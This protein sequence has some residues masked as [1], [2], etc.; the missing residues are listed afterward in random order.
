MDAYYKSDDKNKLWW[1]IQIY[2]KRKYYL[3]LTEVRI[4][5]NRVV[6]S[7]IKLLNQCKTTRRIMYWSYDTC[8]VK[9]LRL[10][11]L[12]KKNYKSSCFMIENQTSY[13]KYCYPKLYLLRQLFLLS[14]YWARVSCLYGNA[15]YSYH[16]TAVNGIGKVRKSAVSSLSIIREL[17][18]APS[19]AYL[20]KV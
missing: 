2:F 1:N 4:F 15:F 11:K 7:G 14:H 17:L 18:S 10:V 5:V 13:E 6:R 16:H 9:N 12:Y 19:V 8:K 20:F 3:K